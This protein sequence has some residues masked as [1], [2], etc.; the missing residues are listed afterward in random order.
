MMSLD[1]WLAYFTV[2][3]YCW[4]L[5]VSVYIKPQKWVWYLWKC[6]LLVFW[7]GPS[8]WQI[9]AFIIIFATEKLVHKF[10]TSFAGLLRSLFS[11]FII[12]H[13]VKIHNGFSLCWN[14][15]VIWEAPDIINERLPVIKD[16]K[17]FLYYNYLFCTLIWKD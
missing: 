12:W 4:K 15:A 16:H 7:L 14:H 6:P 17:V 8:M 3:R 10:L 13:S 2:P 5:K 9:M 11:H 1:L